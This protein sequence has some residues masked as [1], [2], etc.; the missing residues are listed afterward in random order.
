MIGLEFTNES[1]SGH[2]E[3]LGSKNILL[4]NELGVAA[5]QRDTLRQSLTQKMYGIHDLE[6][7]VDQQINLLARFTEALTSSY[8]DKQELQSRV[9]VLL[10][11]VDRLNQE[12][13][14]DRP[15]QPATKP[16]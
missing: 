4:T 6:G 2:L 10:R 12:K 15:T 5:T 1:L 3:E 13:L 16:E 8:E 14:K 9:A 7:K 11:D